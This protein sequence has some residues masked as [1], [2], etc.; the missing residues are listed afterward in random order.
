MWKLTYGSCF[1][2]LLNQG[3]VMANDTCE[4]TITKRLAWLVEPLVFSSHGFSFS[5]Y[6]VLDIQIKITKTIFSMFLTSSCFIVLFSFHSLFF[7]YS[8]KHW[9]NFN[10]HVNISVKFLSLPVSM[11]STRLP[12][13]Y[14]RSIEEAKVRTFNS[15]SQNIH[16]SCTVFPRS[17]S[18]SSFL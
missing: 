2:T 16:F 4:A 1:E 5:S 13:C 7:F 17:V 6:F 15:W 11:D 12:L 9:R 14:N 18:I 10:T 8:L 3:L